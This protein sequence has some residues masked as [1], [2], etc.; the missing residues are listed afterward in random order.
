MLQLMLA[1]V[2]MVQCEHS[3]SGGGIENFYSHFGKQYGSS[4]EN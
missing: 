2:W 3:S 1:R 4:L